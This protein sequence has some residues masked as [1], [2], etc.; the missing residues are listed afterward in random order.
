MIQ[1]RALAEAG[2]K[3]LFTREIDAAMLSGEIDVAVHSSK[4]LPT[5]CPAESGRRLPAERR[6][7]RRADFR[8]GES[9]EGYRRAE[10]WERRRCA[11]RLRSSACAP[12]CKIGLLRGNVE[13]R[14]TKVKHRRDRRHPARLC[15]SQTP[16]LRPSGDRVAG[17]RGF[18][19]RGRT[20]RDRHRRR[21]ATTSRH[22]TRWRPF[23]TLTTDSRD[24]LRTRISGRARRFVPH[25]DRGPCAH[26]RRRRRVS[27][28]G[29]ARRRL[30]DFRGPGA[31]RAEQASR[32]GEDA[33]RD[34]L[35]R[36]P[37]GLLP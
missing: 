20:R 4:D 24:R 23:S 9:I 36:L 16:G 7:P 26:R 32:V 13:T 33:G 27:R 11:A 35:A 3:G 21:A 5:V 19:S 10:R 29:V 2:G 1:D 30:G 15:R 17:H 6:C 25:P 8:R 14:L 18:S 34:L 37:A 28:H 22:W 12:I 31:R